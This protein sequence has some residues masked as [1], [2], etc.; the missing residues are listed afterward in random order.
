MVSNRCRPWTHETPEALQVRCRPFGA[1]T[2][3]HGHLKHQW[4]YKCVAGI[5]GVRNLRVVGESGIEKIGKGG[6]EPL[7]TSPTQ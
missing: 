1:I 3:A 2:A 6:I 4:R 7:V 5:L